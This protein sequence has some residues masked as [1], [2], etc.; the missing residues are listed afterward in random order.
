M[1]HLFYCCKTRRYDRWKIPKSTGLSFHD[2]QSG[3]LSAIDSTSG[4]P[5]LLQRADESLSFANGPLFGTQP[6]QLHVAALGCEHPHLCRAEP[7]ENVR[8]RCAQLL[9]VKALGNFVEQT[10]D[11]VRGAALSLIPPLLTRSVRLIE[12]PRGLILV[13]NRMTTS[14]SLSRLRL[15]PLW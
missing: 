3:W 15:V 8:I 13:A 9:R 7:T 6:K 5:Q 2:C 12:A 10:L 4:V 14:T 1:P 11:E